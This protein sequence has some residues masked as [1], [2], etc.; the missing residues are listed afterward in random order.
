VTPTSAAT[1]LRHEEAVRRA[2]QLVVES[3]QIELDLTA[4]T[5]PT[6]GSR[7]TIR[8]A[9][10]DA[11]GTFVEFRGQRVT[12]LEL[13]GAPLDPA[14]WDGSRIT[15]TGLQRYNTLVVAGEMAY[16]NDGEG[17]HRHVDPQDGQTY[18]Y[19]MSFLDAAPRW[20]ACFDQ[21]DL[22][23]RY[24]FTIRGPADWTVIGNGPTVAAGDGVW[25]IA[26]PHP[27][28]TYFVTLV[29]GRYYSVTAEHDGIRLGL[30]ARAS[31]RDQLRAEAPDL[32]EVTSQCLDYYHRVFDRRYPFGEYHQAFVPDFNAG[33]MENPGC[34]TLRD[35]M[36]FRGRATNADRASRAAVVAHE[37]AHMW[38]GDLVSMRWWDDL[39]LNESFAEYLGQRCV[40]EATIYR[41]WNDFGIVRKDWGSVADQSPSTHPVASN[42]AAD[43]ASALQD[44]DGISYAKGAAVLQQLAAYAGDPAF[45]GGLN[46]YFDRFAF[47]NAAFAD[48]VDAW[49]GAGVPQL[50]RWA[51]AW[52]RTAGMDRIEVSQAGGS[53]V[54]TKTGHSPSRTH[55]LTIGSV[56]PSGA[57]T[58][59]EEV[60]LGDEP[61]VI[62]PP[63]GS[64]LVL[65]DA[66]NATWAKIRCG[67]WTDVGAVLPKIRDDNALVVIVNGIRDAVRE[68]SLAPAAALDLLLA[69]VPGV[70]S[71]VVVAQLFGFV[72]NQLSG[73]YCPS[74]QRSARLARVHAAAL[75]LLASSEAGSDPQLTAF[76]AVIRSSVDWSVLR[77][78]W[79]GRQLPD[80]IDLDPEITWALVERLAVLGDAGPIDETL[81]SDPT[82]SARTHA[83]RARAALPTTDAKAA[84]WALIMQPSEVPAHE[85]YAAC[86]GFFQPSQTDLTAAYVPRYFREIGS[87]DSFRSGWVLG[88]VALLA[89]PSTAA[90]PDTL[91]LAERT[92]TSDLSPLLRRPVV[93]A[94]DQLRRA[95]TS[96]ARYSPTIGTRF[97]PIGP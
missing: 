46:A 77:D 90:S 41:R 76:R 43:A 95:V 67:A 58:V 38:F 9:S 37:M 79:S 48:L 21:P 86:E 55:A 4:P 66:T 39:W 23:S 20:F 62:T 12:T 65:P 2:A 96:L 16:S 28:S 27:L 10:T 53:S 72:T 89:Y 13:N 8:F 56:D 33:A 60:Q 1:S 85:V 74:D 93:D 69:T 17:L 73:P 83:A 31:L 51:D 70:P 32:V 71:E 47:G 7:T 87:T 36:I 61:L 5:E 24:R 59:L 35:G 91:A 42:G 54:I 30:H 94:T 57:V 80:G 50:G 15:L 6:F 64:R 34:V 3:M 40:G 68:A 49:R 14:S 75:D 88:R 84:A 29:A 44:F 78:W 82:A 18:L 45:F 26:P 22:K 25:T 11:T 52:L 63:A 92:L 81:V 97:E 19:A